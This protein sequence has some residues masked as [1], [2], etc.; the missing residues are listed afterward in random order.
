MLRILFPLFI[1]FFL[2][3]INLVYA[4]SPCGAMTIERAAKILGVPAEELRHQASEQMK[5][6][7]FSKDIRT[8]I[9][10]A[11]YQ[12]NDADSAVRSMQKLGSNLQILVNCTKFEGLG[13]DAVSCDG[14]RAKRLLVRQGAT[15][16]DVLSPRDP[17]Q[18]I[19]VAR[20]VLGL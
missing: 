9:S 5:T 18:K 19:E 14:E 13:D 20:M 2:A 6:C 17:D 7:S 15:W 10:F 11:L 4:Q 16:V 3:A 8:M 1:F 12:E